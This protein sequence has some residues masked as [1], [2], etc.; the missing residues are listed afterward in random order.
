MKTEATRYFQLGFVLTEGELRRLVS[1]VEEQLGKVPNG[2]TI[3][4]LFELKFRNGAFATTASLDEVLIQENHGTSSITE[5]Q[6]TS[7]LNDVPDNT[8]ISVRFT[9]PAF[10]SEQQTKPIS[11]VVRGPSRD[12]V[13]VTSSLLEERLLKLKRFPLKRYLGLQGDS[14]TAVYLAFLLTGLIIGMVVY[15]TRSNAAFDRLTAPE[16][17]SV[18]IEE[19]VEAKPFS[20]RYDEALKANNVTDPVAAMLVREQVLEKARNEE[21]ARFRERVR[22]QGPPPR[23]SETQPSLPWTVAI[24]APIP[25]I[26]L[27]LT[28]LFLVLYFPAYNFCWGD[29]LDTFRKKESVKKF[30]LGVLL[31]GLIVSFIGGILA[32][33]THIGR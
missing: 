33:V 31:T 2:K 16:G 4:T 23:L 7:V 11:F 17:N 26:V 24:V 25:L 1:L 5:L 14:A 18:I 29:Y 10:A 21:E 30:I 3:D 32:N 19:A 6:F 28:N 9:N 27:L 22:K 8:S 13:F 15:M 20:Q 12:W